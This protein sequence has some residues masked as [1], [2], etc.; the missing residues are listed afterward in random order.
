M[1]HLPQVAALARN[2]YVVRK[3]QDEDR[4]TVAIVPIH[5]ERETRLEELA[6]MLGDRGS[7][8]ARAH[9]EELLG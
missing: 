7:A 8:S 5:D 4:T 9:A 1:T 6:R 3:L 2:H